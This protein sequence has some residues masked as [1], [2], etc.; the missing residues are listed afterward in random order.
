VAAAFSSSVSRCRPVTAGVRRCP[1]QARRRWRGT[2]RAAGAE[3][4]APAAARRLS[5]SFA[6]APAATSRARR[7]APGMF[8]PG[9]DAAAR[10]RGHTS[11]PPTPVGR[12][13]RYR[14]RGGHGD[15]TDAWPA[16]LLPLS[17]TPAGESSQVRTPC[18]A[19]RAHGDTI[20]RGTGRVACARVGRVAPPCP[21]RTSA[22]SGAAN[23]S[24]Q[25]R[26]DTA[27]AGQSNTSAC[28]RPETC[29]LLAAPRHRTGVRHGTGLPRAAVN[30]NAQPRR[31]AR[32]SSPRR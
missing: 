22:G 20:R 14:W 21:C 4:L 28:A 19:D 2:G 3:C 12:V 8:R 5:A 24:S 18:G 31:T 27:G 29:S 11:R 13:W 6:G 15:G 23:G 16:S 10:L 32:P 7:H 26:A 30:W 17:A 25:R 1:S 9:L